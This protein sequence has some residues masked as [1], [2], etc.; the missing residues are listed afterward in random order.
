MLHR[1][2]RIL[3]AELNHGQLVDVLRARYLVDA[4]PL[5]KMQGRP[6]TVAE[7]REAGERMAVG[8]AVA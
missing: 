8:R 6:F 1:Y 5:N 7:V 4:H 2:R 3:V